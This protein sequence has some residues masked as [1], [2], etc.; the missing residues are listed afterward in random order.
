MTSALKDHM[1]FSLK[2][3]KHCFSVINHV[4]YQHIIVTVQPFIFTPEHSRWA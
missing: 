4:K 2:D 1:I 3:H